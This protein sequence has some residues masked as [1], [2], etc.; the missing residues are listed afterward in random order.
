M[1]SDKKLSSIEINTI[2]R[3]LYLNQEDFAKVIGKYQVDI[4]RYE[5]GQFSPNKTTS[6][7]IADAYMRIYKKAMKYVAISYR[8]PES[9][10]IIYPDDIEDT[11]SKR[12][13]FVHLMRKNFI[14]NLVIWDEQDYKIF[15]GKEEDTRHNRNKWAKDYCKNKKNLPKRKKR[16]EE[17]YEYPWLSEWD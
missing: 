16:G 7:K 10:L 8:L 9:Y 6:K 14:C 3:S 2:R 11:S 17:V 5:S 12:I 4:A 1:I 15:L 13:A